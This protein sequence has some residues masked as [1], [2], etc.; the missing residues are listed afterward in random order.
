MPR[1][2]FKGKNIHYEIDGVGEPVVIL[3]G[4]MMSTKSWEFLVPDLVQKYQLIR[5]DFCDQGQS[6]AM[7]KPYEQDIQVELLHELLKLLNLKEINL[8]GISYGGEV[9]LVFSGTYPKMVK[10]LIIFNSVSY[11]TSLLSNTG[12][13]W[14]DAAKA[15]NSEEYYDLTIP[16]IYSKQFMKENEAWIEN[17]KKHLIENVFSNNDFLDRMIRLT[18]SADNY[19]CR[20]L[21]DNITMP[22][23]IVGSEKDQLTPIS[24]QQHLASQLKNASLVVL[25]NSG[26]ASMYEEPMVFISLILGFFGTKK[27]EYIL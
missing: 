13:L 15:R 20:P 16:V 7:D 17:R 4:I 18:D 24:H 10:R 1:F 25:P 8:V 19:D 27:S 5:L 26:H 6:D 22:T 11:T 2:N 21:L 12:K 23:L 9:A 14:N 3:N